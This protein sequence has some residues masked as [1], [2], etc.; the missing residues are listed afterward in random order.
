MI[1]A[2]GR[3]KH[4]TGQATWRVFTK[5]GVISEMQVKWW[6]T[7]APVFLQRAL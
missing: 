6:P 2:L 5:G 4:G 7:K 1:L 3:I